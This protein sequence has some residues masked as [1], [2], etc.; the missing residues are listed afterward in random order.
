MQTIRELVK[1]W[2]ENLEYSKVTE[3]LNQYYPNKIINDLEIENIFYNETILYWFKSHPLYEA[4]KDMPKEIII[5][6]YLE[7]VNNLKVVEKERGITITNKQKMFDEIEV[8]GKLGD[9]DNY[10]LHF[11][12][13]IALLKHPKY[14]CPFCSHGE[15]IKLKEIYS[16]SI[17]NLDVG[18][19]K[20]YLE[21]D[22]HCF[23]Y[24]IEEASFT[25][26]NRRDHK[27]NLLSEEE[28]IKEAKIV[29]EKLIHKTI[30]LKQ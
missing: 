16:P 23:S 9:F 27:V 28:I 25:K 14:E 21:C 29:F 13:Q 22:I 6:F 18:F 24:G 7:D 5:A 10:K 19:H 30:N 15:T 12:K 2:W 1:N 17:G 8:I 20:I 11:E 4:I 26:C 3:L